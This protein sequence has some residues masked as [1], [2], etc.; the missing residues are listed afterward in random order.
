MPKPATPSINDAASEVETPRQQVEAL[1]AENEHL[2]LLVAKYRRLHFGQKSESQ[3]QLGQLDLALTYE[4]LAI[5]AAESVKARPAAN[6]AAVEK[7][8]RKRKVFPKTLPRETV[9]HTPA[10]TCCP[11]CGGQFKPLGEDVSEMLEYVPASFKVIRHVRAKLAC[12]Q[13]DHIAH[14][15]APSRPIPRG[16]AGPALLAHILVG[17]FCDH[18][19]LY[20]QSA[21]YARSG[22]DMDRALLADW[23]GH[24]HELLSPLVDTIQ[25][26]VLSGHKLHA[27][28]TPLPVLS[29]GKGRTKTARLWTYVRDD[30]PAGSGDPPAVWFA[31]SEDRKGHHPCEHLKPFKGVLQADAYA[32]FN[33]LYETG[34][35]HEAACWAHVRRKFVDVYRAQASPIAAEAIARIAMLYAI[36]ARIRGQF[37]EERRTI[38]QAEARPR[39]HKLRDWMETQ[40]QRVSRK[41]GIADAIGYA[42]NQ[43]S[44]LMRYT[45]DGRIEI[46]NN[47]AERALRSVALGRKNYLFGGSDVGGERATSMYCLIGSAKLNGIDPEAYLRTVL[48]TIAE[49]PINRIDELLPWNLYPDQAASLQKAA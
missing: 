13:C 25:R 31:Y 47:A 3:E 14:A 22:L 4:P 46:D 1:T 5:E 33:A 15:D 19:P 34:D 30:R 49:H 8:P 27:D 21:I 48:A 23:V 42:L 2:K 9:T 36:E 17:K 44:A 38:R 32:G 37:P 16:I 26:Y 28:D 7:R 29:P 35:I 24:C 45:T 41:S 43:W 12:T 10:A 11:D 6:D 40:N 39:L 18:L 20:R